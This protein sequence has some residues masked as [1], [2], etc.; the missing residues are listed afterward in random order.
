MFVLIFFMEA[1]VKISSFGFT[2]YWHV[3][4]NKFDFIVVILS[5]LGYFLTNVNV[6]VLRIIRV[7]RL[8][9]M[10]KTSKSLR[11]LIKT[12][13][14]SLPNIINVGLLL[15]LIF[16]TFSVAGMTLFGDMEEGEF[17]NAEANFKTF[18]LSMMTLIRAATGESW[19]GLMH[20]CND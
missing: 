2:Y 18:F 6:T 8:V 1:V 20:D 3:N 15:C 7:V 9:K 12:L 14:M 16:F 5:L 19:N 10:I 11:G 17:I 4:W 13:Y